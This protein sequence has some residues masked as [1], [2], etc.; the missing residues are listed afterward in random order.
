MLRVHKNALLR[1]IEEEWSPEERFSPSDFD[2]EEIEENGQNFF[3][4]R[5]RNSPLRFRVLSDA[6]S[7]HSLNY[8]FVKMAPGFPWWG[9]FESNS[10]VTTCE[11]LATWLIEDLSTY[12]EEQSAPDLWSQLQAQPVLFGGKGKPQEEMGSFT[13]DEKAAIR[14]AIRQLERQISESFALTSE[15][16]G[17]VHRRLAYL[18]TAVDRLNRFDWSG[19][20][21]NTLL[22]IA[23][24]LSL[25]TE[26]GKQ[27]YAL[28]RAAFSE[29]I[30]MLQ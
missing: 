24:A 27:L 18:G 21:L 10:I 29:I 28:A 3:E 2:G 6:S 25:N 20:L 26:Q 16:L 17:F 23:T 11:G 14:R 13:E 1:V 4:I 7:Y 5:Y 8:Q 9:P 30:R 12:V 19:T 15:Q 22:T